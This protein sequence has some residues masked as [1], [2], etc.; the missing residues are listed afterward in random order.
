M[1]LNTPVTWYCSSE[2]FFEAVN[3]QEVSNLMHAMDHGCK[4]TVID[5]RANISATKAT[6]YLQIRPG[7]DYAFKPG[8]DSR[9]DRPASIR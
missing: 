8:G 2:I 6:R 7:T 3:I 9:T 5:V 4:L 1:T